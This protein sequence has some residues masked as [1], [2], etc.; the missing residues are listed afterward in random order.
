MMMPFSPQLPPRPKE[1]PQRTT[2]GPPVIGTFFKVLSAKN[3]SYCRARFDPIHRHLQTVATARHRFHV[4][5]LLRGVLQRQPYFLD[6]GID[7]V[8]ELDNRVIWPEL[9]PDL[10]ARHHLTGMFKQHLKN[11]EG[12]L[13]KADLPAIPV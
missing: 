13:V 3:P 4:L 12:L 7:A 9:T 10:L 8:V 5:G 6:G 2:G 11:L 1:A